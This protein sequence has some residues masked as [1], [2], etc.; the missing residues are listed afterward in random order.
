MN[1]EESLGID[2]NIG[3][4]PCMLL[5]SLGAGYYICS[6]IMSPLRNIRCLCLCDAA[7]Y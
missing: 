5:G 6:F 4:F 2:C 3:R 1:R 7:L